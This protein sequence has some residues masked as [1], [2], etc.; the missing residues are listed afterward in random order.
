MNPRKLG[1]LVNLALGY[2][3]EV[4]FLIFQRD[5][6]YSLEGAILKLHFKNKLHFKHLTYFCGGIYIS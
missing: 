4:D 6:G 1:A 5:G 3:P 2:F